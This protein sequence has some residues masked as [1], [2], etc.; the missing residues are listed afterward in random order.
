MTST[1][2]F[3]ADGTFNYAP[4]FFDQLYTINGYT[5]GFYVPMAYFLLPNK[6]KKIYADMWLFLQ[7]LCE[8]IVFKNL[9]VLKLHLDFEIGSHE[10]AK[11]VFPNIEIDACR[12]HLG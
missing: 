10:A 11:E 6:S 2:E 4:K 9:L 7:E 3:F 8:K 1:S 5:N 12:F